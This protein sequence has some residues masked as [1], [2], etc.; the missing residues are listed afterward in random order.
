MMRAIQLELC[1]SETKRLVL[2]LRVETGIRPKENHS[3]D[4][5]YNLEFLDVGML[6]E[7]FLVK[8]ISSLKKQV[9]RSSKA[10]QF[11]F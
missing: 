3:K 5:P 6:F 10:I 11:R 7:K 9:T 2:V 8:Q 1:N 4:L